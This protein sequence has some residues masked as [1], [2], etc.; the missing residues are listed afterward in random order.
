[1][2][3][4]FEKHIHFVHKAV[5]VKCMTC[6]N[7]ASFEG[8]ESHI[9]RKHKGSLKLNFIFLEKLSFREKQL[10]SFILIFCSIL[11][12]SKKG[13]FYCMKIFER[14]GKQNFLECEACELKFDEMDDFNCHVKSE[15]YEGEFYQCPRCPAVLSF[16]AFSSHL[17][18]HPGCILRYQSGRSDKYILKIIDQKL[19]VSVEEQ[20]EIK[21]RES[22]L[23][24]VCGI[25]DFDFETHSVNEHNVLT[26][27]CLVCKQPIEMN[28]LKKH[29]L[30]LHQDPNN[31]RIMKFLCSIGHQ[32]T[33]LAPSKYAIS[34]MSLGKQFQLTVNQNF[35]E[36]LKCLPCTLQFSSIEFLN[37]HIVSFHNRDLI[38][39]LECCAELDLKNIVEHIREV[40]GSINDK[41]FNFDLQK[42]VDKILYTFGLNSQLIK[43]Y[44][45]D[46]GQNVCLM[47][48]KNDEMKCEC[49]LCGVYFTKFDNFLKHITEKHIIL[50]STPELTCNICFEEF[51][52]NGFQDIRKH[53][54]SEE[55]QL[56]TTNYSI[57]QKFNHLIGRNSKNQIIFRF[58]KTKYIPQFKCCL[59]ASYLEDTS[60]WENHIIKTHFFKSI[61]CYCYFCKMDMK[62]ESIVA[63]LHAQHWSSNDIDF[64]SHKT[65][66]EL[67]SMEKSEVEACHEVPSGEV[68]QCRK[69]QLEKISKSSNQQLQKICPKIY[70]FDI[71]LDKDGADFKIT[72]DHKIISTSVYSCNVCPDTALP[73]HS[74]FVDHLKSNHKLEMKIHCAICKFYT[75]EIISESLLINHLKKHV[76]DNTIHRCR[77]KIKPLISTNLGPPKKLDQETFESYSLIKIESRFC[78]ILELKRKISVH[79][80]QDCKKCYS[81]SIM[82]YHHI[83]QKHNELLKDPMEAFCKECNQAIGSVYNVGDHMKD[84]H[85]KELRCVFEIL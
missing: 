60:S 53:Y 69:V 41:D 23:C 52:L 45:G 78:I 72:A 29:L 26:L 14:T 51:D 15:H 28:K 64:I 20:N 32:T 40:H 50:K 11:N 82:W 63:H 6:T 59:C 39:C 10:F 62:F 4:D 42:C 44:E 74:D 1:M 12:T 76:N 54:H 65:F 49:T 75:W 17:Q 33:K 37:D 57:P 79:S 58:Q 8:I 47:S 48:K 84:S 3:K 25:A 16:N 83:K 55:V 77:F 80:C 22:T 30:E 61:D 19:Y 21:N 34:L 7:F 67:I 5:G 73:L 46:L 68:L 9:L 27:N 56:F 81:S 38:K 66:E 71:S 31:L 43:N 2:F 13:P 85:V 18:N 70:A 35:I 24:E 36:S